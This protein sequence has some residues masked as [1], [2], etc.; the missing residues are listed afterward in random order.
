MKALGSQL[1]FL[2]IVSTENGDELTT[3]INKKLKEKSI[4]VDDCS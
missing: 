2:R 4:S 3:T 1:N